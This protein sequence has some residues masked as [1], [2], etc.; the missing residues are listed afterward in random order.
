MAT[1]LNLSISFVRI[2]IF[3]I[4]IQSIQEHQFFFHD[5]MSL[6]ISLF[7]CCFNV[8]V[9]ELFHLSGQ[10]YS[11]VLVYFIFLFFNCFTL[12]L[13][14]HFLTYLQKFELKWSPI[15]HRKWHYLKGLAHVYLVGGSLSSLCLFRLPTEWDREFP[16]PFPASSLPACHH[17]PLGQHNNEL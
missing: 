8:F 13:L 16:G 12:A 14:G 11:Q 5:F 9:V 15:A 10:V 6:L 4:L 1:L 3:M 7:C 2:G 17:D